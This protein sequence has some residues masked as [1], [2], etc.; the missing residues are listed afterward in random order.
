MIFLRGL[1]LSSIPLVAQESVEECILDFAVYVPTF[2]EKTFTLKTESLQRSNR[3]CI[4]W[5][6]VGFETTQ[7]HIFKRV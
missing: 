1:A 7:V 5:I 3:S 2:A 4:S 6:D